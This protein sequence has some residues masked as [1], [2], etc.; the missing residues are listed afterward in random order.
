M[1]CMNC[2]KQIDDDSKVCP[3]CGVPVE[4]D[5]EEIRQAEPDHIATEQIDVEP[6]HENTQGEGAIN[7]EYQNSATSASSETVTPIVNMEDINEKTKNKNKIKYVL[8][9][10][11]AVL[12]LAVIGV[13]GYRFIGGA[14]GSKDK[15]EYPGVF[16][17]QDNE[18]MFSNYNK[19]KPTR[20]DDDIIDDWSDNFDYSLYSSR[21]TLTNDGKYIFY[22]QNLDLSNYSY[23]LYY[24]GVNLKKDPVNIAD[25]VTSYKLLENNHVVYLSSDNS[26]YISDLKD[27]NRIAKNVSTYYID[28]SEK[29]VLWLDNDDSLYYQ[30]LDLKKDKEKLDK[31]VESILKFSD[32]FQTIVYSKYDDA[33]Y[34][35]Y[36]IKNFGEKEKILGNLDSFSVFLTDNKVSAYF[37]K[38]KGEDSYTAFDLIEDDFPEDANM[39]Q[40][41]IKDYTTYTTVNGF[42]GPTTREEVD[43]KYYDELDKYNEKKRRDSVRDYYQSQSMGFDD[44]V[45]YYYEEGKEEEEVARGILEIVDSFQ[46]EENVPVLIYYYIDF[47]NIEKVKLSDVLENNLT[48]DDIQKKY[49]ESI[50]SNIARGTE[51]AKLNLDGMLVD[52]TYMY[53]ESKNLLCAFVYEAKD[54]YN[55]SADKTGELYTLSAAKGNLGELNK[56]GTDVDAVKYI[57]DGMVY[58]YTDYDTDDNEGTLYCNGEKVSEDVSDIFIYQND[59]AAFLYFKD[60]AVSDPEGTLY[61]YKNGKSVKVA[62]E[63]Y[64]C[65]AYNDKY[66][67]IITDYSTK[68]HMGDLKVF[69]GKDNIKIASDVNAI[70][71]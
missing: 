31:D 10:M 7:E 18:L 30:A 37:I 32:K 64:S 51:V 12:A 17:L 21:F 45:I 1:Y 35:L 34:D 27:K 42:W 71:Y 4:V 53:D 69:N 43:Q 52:R 33:N 63:V 58:Y 38:S 68:N 56:I 60:F 50:S 62:D 14:S 49:F 22:G 20:V 11:A 5:D 47:E 23:D 70:V 6:V 67:A 65:Y 8:G 57:Q 13:I 25:S 54:M 3:F 16:Y 15:A 40:P 59:D 9:I 29:Y 46:A 66:I 41:D 39:K 61:A 55:D 2:G 26:L 48:Y 19:S 36:V 24:T 28:D 44:S